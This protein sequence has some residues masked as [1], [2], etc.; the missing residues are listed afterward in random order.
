MKILV[1]SYFDPYVG[2]TPF[3]KQPSSASEKTIQGVAALMDLHG[4]AGFFVHSD[5]GVKSANLGFE[6]ENAGARG[7]LESLLLSVIVT[8]GV[9]D[10]TVAENF[11]GQCASQIQAIPRAFAAFSSKYPDHAAKHAELHELFSNFYQMF[12]VERVIKSRLDAKVFVYG[13]AKTGKTTLINRLQHHDHTRTVPTTNV[14]VSKVLLNNLS[15]IT[16]DAPGQEK[17]RALWTPFLDNQDALVFVLDVTRPAEFP[18]ARAV[19]HKI[20]SAE[21]TRHLPLLLMYNKVDVLEPDLAE[22]RH[23][24][25]VT[26]LRDRPVREFL[27]STLHNTGIPEAF[28]WLTGELNREQETGP[29]PERPPDVSQALIFSRWDEDSGLEVIG[30]Y[31]PDKVPDPEVIAIRCFSAAQLIYGGEKFSKKASI[32]VPMAQLNAN[33]AIY[34]DFVKDK[35]TRGGKLP[36]SLVAL[37]DE[38]TR[39]PQI[40]GLKP[41]MF[42]KLGRLKKKRAKQARVNQELQEI[43]A[44]VLTETRSDGISEFLAK[45]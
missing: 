22:V 33:A 41:F 6:I 29:H 38:N 20:A 7:G 39:Q 5:A 16:Y 8:D 2:P 17:F 14:G 12:P 9:L 30:T 36:L 32:V 31:P 1:L 28:E 18:E 34:F 40:D 10:E 43:H 11:L 4:G 15:L 25:D 44:H 45:F 13:L 23:A 3:L 19:L 42:K 37:F 27:T 21:T 24:L 35:H 26:A